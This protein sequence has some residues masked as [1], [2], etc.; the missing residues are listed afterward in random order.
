MS[1]GVE[2]LKLLSMETVKCFFEIDQGYSGPDTVQVKPIFDMHI[3]QNTDDANQYR[4]TMGVRLSSE[5]DIG[6]PYNI[7]ARIRSV[8]LLK[9]IPEDQHQEVIRLK[10]SSIMFPYL[11]S[12]LTSIMTC[13]G[14]TPYYIP[15]MNMDKL[16]SKEKLAAAST[17]G[18][19]IYSDA[20]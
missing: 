19:K 10:C 15:V 5:E 11:R 1:A 9:D 12:T 3:E 2:N 6:F 4:I 13:A 18:Q 20:D 16:F 14:I 7:E 17:K 8:F